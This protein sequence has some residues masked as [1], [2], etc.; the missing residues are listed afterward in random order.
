MQ[1][2]GIERLRASK[3]QNSEREHAEGVKFGK[4]WALEHA[5]YDELQRVSV[6]RESNNGEEVEG[7][8]LTLAIND[9]G[10]PNNSEIEETMDR[11]IGVEYP[12]ISMV[13]GF[14]EGAGEIFDEV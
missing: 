6:L 8:H 4:E 7:Y 5:D 9:D 1:A 13:A 11:V 2:A 14:I 10:D 12:S 3:K